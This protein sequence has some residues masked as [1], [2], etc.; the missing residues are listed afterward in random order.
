M[1]DDDIRAVVPADETR[2][3]RAFVHNLTGH[4]A[5]GRVGWTSMR[6]GNGYDGCDDTGCVCTCHDKPKESD[7]H[8]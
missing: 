1:A 8:R 2:E 5:A 3:Q 4:D 7:D 6:C